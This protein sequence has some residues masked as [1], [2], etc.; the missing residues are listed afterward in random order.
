MMVVQYFLEGADAGKVEIDCSTL[1]FSSLPLDFF[2]FLNMQPS[3][4]DPPVLAKPTKTV[5][6]SISVAKSLQFHLFALTTSFKSKQGVPTQEHPM[7]LNLTFNIA[8][9]QSVIG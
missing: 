5:L 9:E 2:F 4:C 3:I 7:C 6:Y 1:L 8:G